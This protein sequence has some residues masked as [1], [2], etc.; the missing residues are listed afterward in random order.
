MVALYF[1]IVIALPVMLGIYVAIQAMHR[2]RRCPACVG[3]TL[4]VQ[5]RAYDLISML[6]P[7]SQLQLRWCAGC[8]WQGVAR[9]RRDVSV[10]PATALGPDRTTDRI[11]IRRLQIDGRTWKVMIEC[12]SQD[13]RWLGRLMFVGPDGQSHGEEG[14]SLVGDSALE[15]LSGALSIP[16]QALA[17]RLRRAIH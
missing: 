15:V 9:L 3:E 12:W 7:F 11:D 13:G 5:S 4:R 10:S 8:G 1:F 2:S 16:D 14:S 6:F 17:G